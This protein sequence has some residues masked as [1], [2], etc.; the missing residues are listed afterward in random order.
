VGPCAIAEHEPSKP[1]SGRTSTPI[2]FWASESRHPPA[3]VEFLHSTA[4]NA[5]ESNLADTHAVMHML[6]GTNAERSAEL[7]HHH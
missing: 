7:R 5:A 4:A 3:F 1:P 2:S 6:Q